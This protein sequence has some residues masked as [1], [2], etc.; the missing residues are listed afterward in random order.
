MLAVL[1]DFSHFYS[2]LQCFKASKSIKL[3]NTWYIQLERVITLPGTLCIK[4]TSLLCTIQGVVSVHQR[5]HCRSDQ[6]PKQA[7]LNFYLSP[8]HRCQYS[9]YSGDYLLDLYR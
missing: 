8:S 4:D 1:E 3:S 2:F 9:A 5:F 7:K 6:V